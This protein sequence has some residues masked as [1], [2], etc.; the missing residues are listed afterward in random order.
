[1]RHFR[2]TFVFAASVLLLAQIALGQGFQVGSISGTVTDESGGVLPGVTV[3]ATHQERGTQ[4]VEYTDATGKF[5]FVQLP[6]GTYKVDAAL[7]GFQT[8]I[9]DNIRVVV[10]KNT[11]LELRLGLAAT[12]TE[13]TV[14]AE[15]PVVDP[16][17]VA[18]TTNVSVEEFEKAPIGRSYQTIAAL[19][20]GITATSGGNPYSNGALSSSNQFLYDGVDATDPTT[21]TFGSNMNF[22][23]IQEVQV[24]TN[25]VSAE[26]GR[27]TGA[28]IN[29]ITKSGTNDFAGS[30]KMIVQNDSWNEQNKTENSITGASF[31]RTK[32][33][34]DDIRYAGTIGG[35]IL[36]DRAWFFGA[37]EEWEEQAA[38]ATT[39]VTGEDYA[40]QRILEMS[41]YRLSW[42]I[43]PSHQIWA[44]YGEDPM[45]GI[46][47]PYTE[48]T[49]LF[50]LTAQSQGG[51]QTVVQ[52]S[53]VFGSNFALEGMWGQAGSV[54]TVE[55]Y[56]VGPFD[57]GAAIWD[58]TS[59][60][61]YNGN[62]FGIGNGTDR[63][64]D[65]IVAAGTFFTSLGETTH[66][67]KVGGDLQSTE[68][69]S[70]YSYGNNRLYDVEN[71]DAATGT[72][73]PGWRLD[74]DDPG[75][76]TSEGD[77]MSLY[78]RDKMTLTPRLFV[79]AGLRFEDQT[80]N[81]DVGQKIV[82]TQTFAPRFAV[83]YDL[84]GDA[85]TILSASAGRYYDFIIQGFVDDFAQSASRA[86]Y[87]LYE[88]NPDINDYD[89][90]QTVVT[91]GGSTLRPN[92]DLDPGEM[93][94]FTFGI[95]RQLGRTMGVGLRYVNREW[96]NLIDDFYRYDAD[97]NIQTDYVNLDWAGREYQ[98]LQ[99]TFEK[100]FS[101]NWSMMGNYTYSETEGNHFGATATGL[102]DHPGAMCRSTD[103]T[104]GTIP[105]DSVTNV[106]GTASYD[107]PHVLNMLGSYT[108][109]LGPANLTF[110]GA[111]YWNSGLPYSKGSSIR[112]LYPDGTA[113]NQS[114]TYL[115]E[116]R[117]SDRLPDVWTIDGSAEATWNV[118]AGVELGV[119][120]EIFNL[121]DNQD[122]V[123]TTTTTWTNADTAAGAT[124]RSRYGA[125]TARTHFQGPR[126]YRVTG[127]IRF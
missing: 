104:V 54:I 5:R 115:Y 19:A 90:V 116:G 14:T 13:I 80:G 43:N 63:P 92:L 30:L 53:G 122:P 45:S 36:R 8:Q 22:E 96:N 82:D 33:D 67:I 41:N 44:R 27:A 38:P 49:D 108:M 32:N 26:Y 18:Q 94:E 11:D 93:D 28:F 64:R 1:M 47:R 55:P 107:R 105:C 89:F 35:P 118:L 126:S 87:D 61:Y 24:L 72:F 59:S 62:Y 52:Y 110:G 74:Y 84:T 73:T 111:G 57:N 127:L 34:A 15:A 3:T 70:Y 99:A 9:R 6:L 95:Q 112:V 71:Y 78:V 98:A 123:S 76:Q 10:D 42:Q 101:N 50:V 68:S 58:N 7:E 51:D 100:R 16:T 106:W 103:P 113:S 40:S 29:V 119:K 66:D 114:Y 124:T 20:P 56:R 120:G 83:T 75:P 48:G 77:I 39:T 81:N 37:Y 2:S 25:G 91:A 85:R 65:Q 121:T 12:A 117:G 4:R 102:Y 17:N 97:R 79:E 23:A 46:V 109:N 31:A 21:G 86:N 69:M 60:K 88:W 125:Q